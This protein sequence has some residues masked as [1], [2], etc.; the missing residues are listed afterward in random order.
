MEDELEKLPENGARMA[1]ELPDVPAEVAPQAAKPKPK[2]SGMVGR[3]R[4]NDEVDE[5]LDYIVVYGNPPK[6]LSRKMRL[7][8]IRHERLEERRKLYARERRQT[9]KGQA[10]RHAS[11]VV[12]MRR[13]A[14][15][16]S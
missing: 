8:Y 1:Q 14:G 12:S 16:Q 6:G 9:S 11:N 7:Y 10:G 3:Q 5:I 4:T 13:R 15:S 2:F